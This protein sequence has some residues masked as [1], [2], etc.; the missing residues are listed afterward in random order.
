MILSRCLPITRTSVERLWKRR[1]QPSLS[2][3]E[4]FGSR[5]RVRRRAFAEPILKYKR[6]R[7]IAEAS[8][9]NLPDTFR[10]TASAAIFDGIDRSQGHT[11]VHKRSYQS[12]NCKK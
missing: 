1:P 10:L 2:Y 12:G 6:S 11:N 3:D 7:S 8:K 4:R 9:C 5:S